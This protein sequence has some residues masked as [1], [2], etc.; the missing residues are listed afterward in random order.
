MYIGEDSWIGTNVVISGSILIGKHCVIG[1][2]SVVMKNIPDYC[3]AVGV[4]C[5]VVKQYDFLTSS[6]KEYKE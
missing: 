3:V 1:A 6:W 2:N 4:P 5:R